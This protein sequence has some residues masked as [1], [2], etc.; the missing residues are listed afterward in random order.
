[1]VIKENLVNRIPLNFYRYLRWKK[2]VAQ[3]YRHNLTNFSREYADI[4]LAAEKAKHRKRPAEEIL[5]AYSK[6]D[7]FIIHY[8][9]A[10][11]ADVI[12][13]YRRGAHFQPQAQQK[14]IWVFW[15][16]GED[17]A[18]DIV[19]AS[20]KSIRRNANGHEVVMLDRNNIQDYVTLPGTILEKHEKGVIT[21]AHFADIV[22]LTLLSAWGGVWIDATVFLSQP[23][24]EY[25]FSGKFYTLKSY[26]PDAVYFSKS[27]WCGYFLAGDSDFLMFHFAKDFL[28]TYWE[29]AGEIID[30]LL[31]DY[32]FGIAY[33]YFDEVKEG[34]D[35]VPNNNSL[36][37]KLMCAMNQPYSAELFN[38]L[39][40]RDT[41]ASKLSWRYGNP[42][43]LTSDGKLSNYGY[44]INL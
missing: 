32:V 41:F 23:I 44:L 9:E 20:I 2:A 40:T 3:E 14:K 37:G 21:H 15:W 6:K 27:R 26:T 30:Y 10:L 24:P 16:S 4:C 38:S 13:K 7:E 36:R 33:R 8:L 12:E 22:R 39:A 31:M 5:A 11:C 42:K 25:V 29:R 19:K 28:L 43:P 17:S 1:M 18:P 34:I 35:S